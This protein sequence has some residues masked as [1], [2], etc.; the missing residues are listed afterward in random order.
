MHTEETAL[1]DMLENCL[2]ML[3]V[4]RAE[5]PSIPASILDA[6]EDTCS[7]I[8]ERLAELRTRPKPT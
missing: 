2:R 3:E 4:A 5:Q 7:A 6:M 1:S 8:R